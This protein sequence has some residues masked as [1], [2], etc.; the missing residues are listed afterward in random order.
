MKNLPWK[1]TVPNKAHRPVCG[2]ACAAY[3]EFAPIGGNVA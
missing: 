3:A 1:T 2:T